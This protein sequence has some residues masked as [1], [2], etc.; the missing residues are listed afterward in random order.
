MP[1]EPPSTRVLQFLAR[2]LTSPEQYPSDSEQVLDYGTEKLE[3]AII[4][5][6]SDPA[7]LESRLARAKSH[8]ER[9]HSEHVPKDNRNDLEALLS[10]LRRADPGGPDA[11]DLA[12]RIV[13]LRDQ[14]RS[15]R[16]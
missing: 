10:D 5:L 4:A 14:V 12:L 13:S 2:D 7:S 11:I 3:L 16:T 1:D 15:K 6:V 9:L 8:V